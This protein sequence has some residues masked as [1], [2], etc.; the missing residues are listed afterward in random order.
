MDRGATGVFWFARRLA[1]TR[2]ELPMNH[3]DVLTKMLELME[4]QLKSLP[5]DDDPRD[6]LGVTLFNGVGY[7]APRKSSG[8]LR[9]G[10]FPASY[11]VLR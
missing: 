10:I 7:D 11:K 6:E 2:R 1:P 9:T 4:L 3:E 8:G 5:P